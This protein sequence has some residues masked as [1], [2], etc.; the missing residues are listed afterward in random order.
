MKLH[1]KYC[2]WCWGQLG[3][4]GCVCVH[5]IVEGAAEEGGKR[6]EKMSDGVIVRFTQDGYQ[7]F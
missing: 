1:T 4:I 5:D 3:P 2:T 7:G 6:L